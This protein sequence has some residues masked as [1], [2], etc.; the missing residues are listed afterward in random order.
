MQLLQAGICENCVLLRAFLRRALH[1]RS[2]SGNPCYSSSSLESDAD[3][4]HRLY[5]DAHAASLTEKSVKKRTS[6]CIPLVY[7]GTP[8]PL[9]P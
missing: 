1:L 7:P 8:E 4:T 5:L 3:D 9:P 6:V 2:A